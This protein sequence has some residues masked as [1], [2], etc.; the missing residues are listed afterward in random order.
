MLTSRLWSLCR[1]DAESHCGVSCEPEAGQDARHPVRGNDHV[2]KFTGQGGD[3]CSTK[4]SQ[5]WRPSY[6]GGISR[7]SENFDYRM[8]HFSVAQTNMYGFV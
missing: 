4:R 5:H 6:S 2:C 1:P 8:M 7:Y 3:Y